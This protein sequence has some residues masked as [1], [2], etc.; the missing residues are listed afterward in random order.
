VLASMGTR[1]A[2]LHDVSH[3]IV[4]HCA[5]NHASWIN[6]IEIWS[7][8]LVRKLLRR[9]NFRSKEHLKQR[10]EAFSAYF[11]VTNA[12]LCRRIEGQ[13]ATHMIRPGRVGTSGG[14]YWKV[15]TRFAIEVTNRGV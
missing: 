5:P 14:A 10:T 1:K 13:G 9:R 6:P 4:L 2:F 7:S 3:R 11:N 8:I 15:P 12:K